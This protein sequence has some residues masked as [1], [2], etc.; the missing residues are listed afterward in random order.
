[1]AYQEQTRDFTNK[2]GQF[3]GDKNKLLQIIKDAMCDKEDKKKLVG[4]M[5][6]LDNAL[7]YLKTRY[8]SDGNLSNSSF[9][10]L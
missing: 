4:G 8:N 1:M 3:E 10:Y 7:C 2:Q 9:S 6:N 5:Y